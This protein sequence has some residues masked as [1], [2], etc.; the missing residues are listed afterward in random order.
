MSC[1]SRGSIHTCLLTLFT[2]CLLGGV[3]TT[4]VSIVTGCV[5]DCNDP[6]VAALYGC[7]A[8]LGMTGLAV[9][10]LCF[11]RVTDVCRRLPSEPEEHDWRLI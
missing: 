11:L 10:I 7:Y 5:I 1:C 8:G 4:I 3:A 6:P 2:L 9:L